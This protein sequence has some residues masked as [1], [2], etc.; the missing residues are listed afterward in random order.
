MKKNVCVC[1]C[2]TESLCCTA[3]I[4][5]STLVLLPGKSHGQ[6]SLA[7]CSPWGY[8]ELDATQQLTLSSNGE[9]RRCL[10]DLLSQMPLHRHFM[11]KRDQSTVAFGLWA[12]QP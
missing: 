10:T 2:I 5:Q 9:G 11:C 6:R 7:G 4:W 1:V 12:W 3:E 8:K